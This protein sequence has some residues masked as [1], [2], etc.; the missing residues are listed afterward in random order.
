MLSAALYRPTAADYAQQDGDNGNDQQNVNQT[1][2][3]NSG[4]EHA[5]IAEGPDEDENDGD[6]IQQ[7]AHDERKWR[8]VKVKKCLCGFVRGLF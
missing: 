3:L 5:K 4:S 7:V 1:I 2:A 6:D 8:E